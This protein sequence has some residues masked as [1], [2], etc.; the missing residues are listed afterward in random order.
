MK[1]RGRVGALVACV[2][3]MACGGSAFLAGCGGD[4]TV[5]LDGGKESGGPDVQTDTTPPPDTSVPDASDA[6]DAFVEASYDGAVITQ[7]AKDMLT[8]MCA[9]YSTCCFTDA[10]TFDEAACEALVSDGWEGANH[11][12]RPDIIGT[13]H[14]AIDGVAA[15][16]CLAGLKTFSCPSITATEYNNITQNCFGAIYG[17]IPIGQGGCTEAAECVK[18]AYCA[19]STDGGLGTCAAI[20]AQGAPCTTINNVVVN[21]NYVCAYRGHVNET[22]YCDRAG[23]AKCQTPLSNGTAC[24]FNFDC[25]SGLC[26]DTNKCGDPLTITDPQFI[27]P[28]FKKDGG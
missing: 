11:E 28:L 20:P 16:S 12:L 26:G 4:D 27:C 9:R 23:T 2:A 13:G 5:V 1:N 3:L 7:F 18:G 15:T 10:A 17:T 25:S 22:L 8:T 21:G 24:N 6:S 14:L 19:P